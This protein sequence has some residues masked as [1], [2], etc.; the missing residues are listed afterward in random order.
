MTSSLLSLLCSGNGDE[1][2][3]PQLLL[4]KPGALAFVLG[5]TSLVLGQNHLQLRKMMEP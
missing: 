5:L 1:K 2:E 4:E 3:P